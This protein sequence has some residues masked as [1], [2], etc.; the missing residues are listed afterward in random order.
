ME[1]SFANENIISVNN[2]TIEICMNDVILKDKFKEN[3][4]VHIRNK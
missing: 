3:P 1:Q 4:S 2:D